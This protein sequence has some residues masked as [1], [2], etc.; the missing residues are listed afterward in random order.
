MVRISGPELQRCSHSLM[1]SHR[2]ADGVPYVATRERIEAA[3]DPKRLRRK[4]RTARCA[5]VRGKMATTAMTT[6]KAWPRNCVEAQATCEP[7]LG[8]ARLHWPAGGGPAA[9]AEAE[10]DAE[11]DG[12]ARGA[13]VPLGE[14][15]E[16]WEDLLADCADSASV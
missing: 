15:E 7:P 3:T 16:A 13:P 11:A 4:Q 2:S 1:A 6:T 10:A 5:G 9:R 14:E 8:C 12:A